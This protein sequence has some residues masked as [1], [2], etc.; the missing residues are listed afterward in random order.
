MREKRSEEMES[1]EEVFDR[2][3][4]MIVYRLLN[5]GYIKKINGVVRSGKESRLYWGVGRR[6]KPIAI[7]IFLTTSAEFLKGRM[8]YLQGDERFKSA[9]KDTR[10]LI[11]LWALKEFKNLQL[12]GEVGLRVPAPLKVDGNVLLME[13]V[14]KNGEPA[15]LLRETPLNHPARI[16]DK[17]AEAV[18]TLYQKAKLVHGD[19]SEYNIMIANSQPI[20]FDF[21]Q[22][23]ITEHPMARSFLERDLLRMNEYFSKIGVI[24]PPIERL[25]KWVTGEDVDKN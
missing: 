17:I 13:F 8:M 5:R 23:V 21:A 10:S 4:L 6:N 1:L 18:R 25:S 16:Y 14:G 15:P 20:I 9:R 2:S 3:T 22:A 7:K 19:L 12:A 11:N 24:V